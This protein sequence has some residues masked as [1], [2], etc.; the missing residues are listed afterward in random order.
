MSA[1][2]LRSGL[3]VVGICAALAVGGCASSASTAGATPTVG[4]A[5]DLDRDRAMDPAAQEGE[6]RTITASLDRQLMTMSGLEKELGGAQ[7]ADAAYATLSAAVLKAS[8]ATVAE[9][10]FGRFAAHLPASDTPSIGGMMFGNYLV[11]A[12]GTGAVVDGTNN[13]KPGDPSTDTQS[14][15]YAGEG[16][17]GSGELT[18]TGAANKAEL[19]AGMEITAD[20]LTG[21]LKSIVTIAPCPDAKGQFTSTTTMTASVTKAGGSTGSNVTIEQTIKGQVDDNAQLVGYDAETRTQTAQFVSGKGQ[22]I[23]TSLGWTVSGEK[24]SNYH[25]GLNRTGGA[26]TTA[27]AKENVAWGLLTAVM[28]Q[29]RAVE[30]AQKG[31]ESGRCVALEPTT[32]PSK[33]TGLTPSATV[34]I[35]A[36]PRSKVDGQPVGGSVTATLA[37]ETSV[38][39]AGSKVKA[40]ATFSYV[41]PAEKDKTAT[42]SLEARSKRGVAKADVSFNTKKG[43]YTASGGGPGI[44]VTGTVPDLAAPFTLKGDG[45]GFTVDFDYTP[46]ADGRSGSLAYSGKGGG[47]SLKGTGTY[48]VTGREGEVLTMTVKN[49]GC[50]IPGGCRN[51]TEVITLT[52]TA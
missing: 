41:A 4:W 21:K 52:P 30:A 8:G 17:K 25:G 33:R 9:P 18:I 31:W 12:L 2:P 36:A 39:P 48:T 15:D 40:D 35:T 50:A 13:L 10:S 43:G 7:A 22:F 38:S 11:V 23:D 6:L 3:V 28:I 49:Y 1:S 14:K 26:V 32:S 51:T 37:G 5:A 16:S 27:F 19:T 24:W 34:S 47:V 29:G 46:A 45:A 42:V 20:G 44:T